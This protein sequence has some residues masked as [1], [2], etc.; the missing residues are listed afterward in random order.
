MIGELFQFV[1]ASF[2]G[3]LGDH[4]RLA[5]WSVASGVASML[6]YKI[7]SPQLKIRELE[8]EAAGIRQAL[9]Q[10]DGEFAD[11]LPLIRTN[12]FIALRRLRVAFAPSL[13]AGLPIVLCLIGLD[14]AYSDFEFLPF[15]P[16]WLRWWVVG[17]FIISSAAALT[18]KLAF[19]I[20]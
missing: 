14:A 13:L 19:R 6:L 9:A 7:T 10:H 8:A 1:D 3:L 15:G 16:A 12:L 2:A 5:V 4:A 18:T 11:A 17:Y 20:K